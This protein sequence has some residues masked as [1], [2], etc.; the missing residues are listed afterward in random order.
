[1]KLRWFILVLTLLAAS[2]ASAACLSD[3]DA[4]RAI[5]QGGLISLREVM[6]IA[7][8]NGG[9]IVSAKL[10]EGSGG[11][12]YRVAVIDNDGRVTRLVIDAGSGDI[13]RGK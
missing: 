3:K 5:T 13:I 10:C 11:L 1:M 4:R 6:A 2:P 12:V 9:D 8:Q 7:R